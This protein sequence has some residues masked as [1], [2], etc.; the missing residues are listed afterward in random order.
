MEKNKTFC[1]LFTKMFWQFD[2]DQY[3]SHII[4]GYINHPKYAYII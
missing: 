1:W 2:F 3:A 4:T